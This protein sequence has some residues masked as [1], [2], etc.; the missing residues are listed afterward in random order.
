MSG[1][2]NTRMYHLDENDPFLGKRIMWRG[3][4]WNR[5]YFC[6]RVDPPKRCNGCMIAVYCDHNCEQSHANMVHTPTRC[7][8]ARM[9][10]K[11]WSDNPLIVGSDRDK[12]N[13][14]FASRNIVAGEEIITDEATV[15]ILFAE[16][17]EEKRQ[18]W[19]NHADIKQV[20]GV[21]IQYTYTYYLTKM[22]RDYFSDI[23]T[24]GIYSTIS[25]GL[26]SEVKAIEKL[27]EE[28]FE[29]KKSDTNSNSDNSTD[30]IELVKFHTS[31]AYGIIKKNATTY[32]TKIGGL[33]LCKAFFPLISLVNH[34]CS[35]NCSV[36][37]VKNG[38]MVLYATRSIESGEELTIDYEPPIMI[39]NIVERNMIL[40]KNF[41]FTCRCK[42]CVKMYSEGKFAVGNCIYNTMKKTIDV[43]EKT[44]EPTYILDE[45][46]EILKGDSRH[47]NEHPRC[48]FALL[49]EVFLI[50]SRRDQYGPE[51]TD[52][53]M[54]MILNLFSSAMHAL[55]EINLYHW[56]VYNYEVISCSEVIYFI[57]ERFEKNMESL[58]DALSCLVEGAKQEDTIAMRSA[59]VI[60]NINMLYTL[61]RLSCIDSVLL[62]LSTVRV[63]QAVCI[64]NMFGSFIKVPFKQNPLFRKQGDGIKR[65]F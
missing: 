39:N 35:P 46:A 31:L 47:M 14:V 13:C 1:E 12:A 25:M 42:A 50:A 4:D 11:K 61:G 59:K 34:S 36:S 44:E 30:D 8:F 6:G 57:Y 55:T 23:A 41:D 33:H 49:S 38:E 56:N 21:E 10:G 52:G 5:C 16:N 53:V 58:I 28:T 26:D 43:M 9:F 2:N 51:V 19:I 20:D 17:I 54:D 62:E 64:R 32:K 40:S 65:I 22:L 48:S 29:Q 7:K 60:L 27:I 18:G 24:M 45:L 63:R 3:R 15:C 37:Y